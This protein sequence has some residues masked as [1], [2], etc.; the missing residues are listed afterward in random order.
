MAKRRKDCAKLHCSEPPF[1]SGLCRHHHD[2][3]EAKRLR[4]DAALAAL[5][6][7]QIDN[8][9]VGPGLLRD[10][11]W[12]LRDWWFD[13]GSYA[14]R[15]REH[16]VLLDETQYAVEWCVGLAEYLVDDERDRR[17]GKQDATNEYFRRQ[18]WDRFE[19][20]QR[21]LMSNGIPRPP[22]RSG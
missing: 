18:L 8:A 9:L 10:E 1:L 3:S 20:L 22:E 5:N 4:R 11:F 21:G 15:N 6:T 19:N 7:G 13:V 12:R 14:S 17:A 2:E 16:P